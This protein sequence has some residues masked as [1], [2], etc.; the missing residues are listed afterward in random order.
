MAVTLA[1]GGDCLS[2]T[3]MLRDQPGLAGRV[4][5]PATMWR[6]IDQLATTPHMLEAVRA[7]R[8]A[9][10]QRVWALAGEASPVDA[11][12]RITIDLDATIV[13]AH[14]DKQH[15]APTWKH[16][17]GFH[18]L[19]AFVDHG[20]A[21]TGEP[22]AALLRPGNAGSN[23]ATDHIQLTRQAL[24]QLPRPHRR[25]RH[26]LIRTDSAGGTHQF[27]SW[28]TRRGRWL[29]YSVGMTITE[30]IHTAILHI[31]RAAWAPA[32]DA[33]GVQRDGAWVAEITGML[34]LESWPAG[35]R[36]IVRKER[37]H[38]GAQLRITDIDGNRITCLATNTPGSQLADL[39]LRHRR[40]AR[41]EDRIR[42]ARATGL[43]NLPFRGFTHN[44]T[45]LDIYALAADLLAW[46]TMLALTGPARRW[47]PKTLR[48][49][50]LA[51][52]GRIIHTGRR[53]LLRLPDH[54]PWT[55]LLLA[56]LARLDELPAPG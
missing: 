45:W 19:L 52:A 49:R 9:V 56:A 3:A 41:C 23:T 48:L 18:P 51:T 34:N 17:Y 2:D 38:P 14:S 11:N 28:L 36:L 5:S 43:T 10:R 37:P 54:W 20:P 55:D 53:L 22:V 46:T 7:A 15:A 12:G 39:E 16:T 8:S 4:A 44:Q 47:E 13:I 42:A 40:R 1:A 24:A 29:S 33:D 35:I 21:G 31:P 26:T 50:L 6:L 27:L 25:G 32:Y 30:D